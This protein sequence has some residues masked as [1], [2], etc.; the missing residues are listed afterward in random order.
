[1]NGQ[2]IRPKVVVTQSDLR[3]LGRAFSAEVN[4]RHYHGSARRIEFLVV[5]GLLVRQRDQHLG[6]AHE[7]I[8]LTNLGRDIYCE[9]LSD[10]EDVEGI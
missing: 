8:E 6:F 2:N 5:Q 4:G 10:H 3:I 7:W 9:S 1:M